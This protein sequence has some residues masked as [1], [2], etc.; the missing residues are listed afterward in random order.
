MKRTTM[1][2]A[3]AVFACAAFAFAQDNPLSADTKAIYNLVKSTIVRAADKM[4]EANYSFKPTEDVR[5]FGEIVG[6]I[7]D[8]QYGFCGAVKGEK[9]AL[10][11]EKTKTSKADLTAALKAAFAYCDDVYNSMTDAAAAEKIDFFGGK[12]TKLAALSYNNAHNDEHY[13]N[14]VTYMRLKGLVPPSSESAGR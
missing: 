13:G 6:H 4:P 9:K 10:N 12:R 3:C 1:S 14:I 2:I 8:A 11:I 7:A 5:S